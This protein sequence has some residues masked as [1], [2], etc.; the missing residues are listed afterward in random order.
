MLTGGTAR[1]S[2][3][4]FLSFG[5]LVF[6]EFWS[7]GGLEFWRFFG[8]LFGEFWSFGVWGMGFRGHFESLGF[9]CLE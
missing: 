7:F 9:F 4:R 5:V 6:G 8:S 3:E 2:K 1:N